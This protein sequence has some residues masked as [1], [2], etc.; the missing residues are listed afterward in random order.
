MNIKIK[1]LG[2]LILSI[3]ISTDGFGF[4][5]YDTAL[6]QNNITEISDNSDLFKKQTTNH[7]K[8]KYQQYFFNDLDNKKQNHYFYQYSVGQYE[9][10]TQVFLLDINFETVLL[11]HGYLDHAGFNRPLVNF[12]LSNNYNVIVFD[13][14]GHGLSSGT[15]SGIDDFSTY[16]QVITQTINLFKPK[17]KNRIHVIGHSTG[18]VGIMGLVT[19]NQINW[20]GQTI[21]LSPLIRSKIWG[22]SKFFYK[23]GGGL[24]KKIPRTFRNNSHNKAFKK[25]LKKEPFVIK[26]LSKKWINAHHKWEKAI[27]NNPISNY[28]LTIIQGQNDIIVDYKYNQKYLNEFFPN[29]DL[30]KINNAN[31]HL[32]N[33]TK[34]I[35][36]QVFENILLTLRSSNK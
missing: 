9:I 7:S 1:R 36:T 14:P 3:T 22:L 32:I 17:L 19:D 18:N 33:E 30:I 8:T 21:L 31:H 23:I 35:Q 6:L 13:Q 26:K 20:N 4:A 15:R 28:K 25:W 12:L 27:Q 29:L 24:F 11:S 16:K 5:A 34:D 2:W 10:V